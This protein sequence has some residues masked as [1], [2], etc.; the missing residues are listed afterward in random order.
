VAKANL[1]Y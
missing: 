1:A